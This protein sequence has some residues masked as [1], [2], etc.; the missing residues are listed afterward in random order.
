MATKIAQFRRAGV[1]TL[2]LCCVAVLY[3]AN[4]ARSTT[5]EYTFGGTVNYIQNAQSLDAP[6]NQA[7]VGDAWQIT[8]HFDDGTY[9]GDQQGDGIGDYM[10]AISYFDF[11]ISDVNGPVANASGNVAPGASYLRTYDGLKHF[12]GHD[13]YEAF[14]PFGSN[15]QYQWFMQLQDS[16]ATAWTKAGFLPNPYTPDTRESLPSCMP[17]RQVNP[18]PAVLSGWFNSRLFTF[19][20]GQPGWGGEIGGSV[21]WHTSVPEPGSLSLLLLGGLGLLRRR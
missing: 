15:Y 3:P 12:V 21:D 17:D 10:G 11:T 4:Q 2:A 7:Q 16:T 5:I 1:G 20:Q 14:I 13:M 18:I 8:Y 9:D 6:W 19:M